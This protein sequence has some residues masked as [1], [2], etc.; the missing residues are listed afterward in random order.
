[1]SEDGG[2]GSRDGEGDLGKSRVQRLNTDDGILLV[3]KPE[4]TQK[5]LNLQIGVN[6]P[7]TQVVT[8]LVGNTRSFGVKLDVDTITVRASLEELTSD[9]DGGSVGVLSIVDTLGL[10]QGTGRIFTYTRG[11]G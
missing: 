9:V 4:S 3:V 7:D 2:V 11:N 1:M 5:A 8:M 6:G 10:G